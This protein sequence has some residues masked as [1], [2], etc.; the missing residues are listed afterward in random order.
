MHEVPTIPGPGRIQRCWMRCGFC[1]GILNEPGVELIYPV[2]GSGDP[3]LSK[4]ACAKCAPE[5]RKL[6][7]EQGLL[8][9]RIIQ[10]DRVHRDVPAGD[11]A[12]V[13]VPVRKAR[14]KPV[15]QA[16]QPAA[17]PLIEALTT[18]L[19]GGPLDDPSLLKLVAKAG[20]ATDIRKL[21]Q[22]MYK[23]RNQGKVVK[24]ENKWLLIKS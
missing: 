5:Q 12:A 6:Q 16:A 13:D 3:N 22:G 18:A 15:K 11:E 8:V 10:P 19:S 23:L 2:P 21:Q 17:S 9:G 24:D 1:N 7:Q 14:A 4:K 20:V